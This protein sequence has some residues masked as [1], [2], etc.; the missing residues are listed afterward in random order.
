MSRGEIF[1]GQVR[2][3]VTEFVVMLRDKATPLA[4]KVMADGESGVA[5]ITVIR[6][7]WGI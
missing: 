2:D 5:S 6:G 7:V 3:P 1:S 4:V